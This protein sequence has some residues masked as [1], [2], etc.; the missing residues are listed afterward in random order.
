MNFVQHIELALGQLT[1][2]KRN[3]T[4]TKLEIES[5]IAILTKSLDVLDVK[6]LV[7]EC[8]QVEK[9][10][11]VLSDKM[12]ALFEESS[13]DEKALDEVSSLNIEILKLEAQKKTLK[14]KLP[15]VLPGPS[16]VGKPAGKWAEAAKKGVTEEDEAWK[17]AV[18]PKKEIPVAPKPSNWRTVPCEHGK[19]CYYGTRC[20]FLHTDE[21]LDFFKRNA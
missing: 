15:S 19:K 18:T 16:P 10:I 20:N 3:G 12:R 2:V 14:A 21:E 13:E 8:E 17:P 1:E 7:E 11:Q 5:V 6:R 9:K 4:A